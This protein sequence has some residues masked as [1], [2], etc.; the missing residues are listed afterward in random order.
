[1]RLDNEKG[2]DEFQEYHLDTDNTKPDRKRN[3]KQSSRG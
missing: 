2:S 3:P 1:V